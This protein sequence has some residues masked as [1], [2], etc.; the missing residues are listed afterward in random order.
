MG[1]SSLMSTHHETTISFPTIFYSCIII[2]TCLFSTIAQNNVALFL[3][4]NRL[5]INRKCMSNDVSKE[6][7]PKGLIRTTINLQ[8]MV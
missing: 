2:R 5:M 7:D 8:A 3:C 1:Q 6:M 4:Y